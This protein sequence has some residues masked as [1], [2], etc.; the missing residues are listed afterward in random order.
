MSGIEDLIQ[1]IVLFALPVI[2]AIT[3]HEAAHGYVARV[4]GDPTA[5]L[6][7]RVTLNPTKHIDPIGKSAVPLGILLMSKLFGGPPL[8]FGWAKPVPVDFGRLKNPKRDM[9]WVALAGPAAN[10]FMAILWAMS[11][12]FLLEAGA[13]RDSFWFQMAVIGIQINLVLMALNLLPLLP[14]DGGRI[15]YSLLPHQLAWQYG[16]LEPYG[17]MILIVLLVTGSLWVF[18]EPFMALGRWIVQLFL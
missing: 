6:A 14:L 10:L 16:R 11:V 3:L 9:R 18:L 13:G 4:F 1:T 15:L 2:F 12:R 8:L 5:T 7:G 17:M